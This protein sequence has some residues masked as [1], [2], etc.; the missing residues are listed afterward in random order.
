MRWAVLL[1]ILTLGACG[2][3]G[4]PRPPQSQQPAVTITGDATIGV[5]GTL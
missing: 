2:V 3:D 1:T 4:E 5:T